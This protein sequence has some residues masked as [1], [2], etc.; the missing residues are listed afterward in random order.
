MSNYVRK[1]RNC[2][3]LCE[4]PFE[5]LCGKYSW[6]CVRGGVKDYVRN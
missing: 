1:L 3:E 6:N 4:E 2:E 5:E